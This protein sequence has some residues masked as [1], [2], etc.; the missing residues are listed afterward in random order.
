MKNRGDELEFISV[1]AEEEDFNMNQ[2][3]ASPAESTGSYDSVIGNWILKQS[4]VI[5]HSLLH[6]TFHS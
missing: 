5:K 2:Q 4:K 3:Y 1:G 6:T